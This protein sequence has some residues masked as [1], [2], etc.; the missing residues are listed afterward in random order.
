M[1]ATREPAGPRWASLRKRNRSRCCGTDDAE[2]QPTC[3]TV[4]VCTLCLTFALSLRLA[5]VSDLGRDF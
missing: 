1:E 4:P 2:A 3:C 5:Q